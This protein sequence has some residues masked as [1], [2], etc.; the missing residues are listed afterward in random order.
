MNNNTKKKRKNMNLTS[1]LALVYILAGFLPVLVILAVN[2]FEMRSMFSDGEQKK[3]ENFLRL[4]VEYLDDEFQEYNNIANYFAGQATGYTPN[5]TQYN[6]LGGFTSNPYAFTPVPGYNNN[7]FEQYSN[8]IFGGGWGMSGSN[9]GT[10][11]SIR[12]LD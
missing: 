5:I 11:S 1:K 12:I 10:G 7:N 6:N 8:G 4:T 2:F 9:Y 3:N